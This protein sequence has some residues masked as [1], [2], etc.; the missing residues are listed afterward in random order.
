M[1]LDGTDVWD[2]GRIGGGRTGQ[3]YR[4]HDFVC[5]WAEHEK[6]LLF[7]HCIPLSFSPMCP[8]PF[9]LPRSARRGENTF[10]MGWLRPHWERRG[11]AIR[12]LTRACSNMHYQKSLDMGDILGDRFW[13][14]SKKGRWWPWCS[15]WV[16]IDIIT[17]KAIMSAFCPGKFTFC[18]LGFLKI[19]ITH[20]ICYTAQHVMVNMWLQQYIIVVFKRMREDDSFPET[21]IS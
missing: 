3:I 11:G 21:K 7:L 18:I 1:L 5:L 20:P 12:L 2:S 14:S 8:P 13:R 19:K 17:V 15:A 16:D 6:K 10:Q 9:H 4:L